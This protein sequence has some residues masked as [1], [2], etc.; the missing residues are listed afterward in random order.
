MKYM[1]CSFQGKKERHPAAC[2]ILDDGES[3]SGFSWRRMRMNKR[4][5][6]RL[7]SLWIG[8]TALAALTL[9][10][11]G[12]GG[13]GGL[14]IS[15]NVSRAEKTLPEMAVPGAQVKAY[16]WPDLA[17][18]IRSATTNADGNY[19]MSLPDSA[20]GKD[21][22][23]VADSDTR[24]AAVI[25]LSTIITDM[26]SGGKTV[27]DL[28]ASTTLAAETVV[29]K[30]K[31][32]S[33]PDLTGPAIETITKECRLWEGVRQMNLTPDGPELPAAFGGGLK[34]PSDADSFI[35]NSVIIQKAL[36]L[37]AD[38]SPSDVR[39]A[40]RMVQ[41]LRDMAH[42]LMDTA[43]VNNHSLDTAAR[44]QQ[45]IEDGLRVVSHDLVVRLVAVANLVGLGGEQDEKLLGGKN[46]DY[47][48]LGGKAPGKYEWR[49]NGDSR[50]LVKVAEVLDGKTWMVVSKIP[51]ATE[52]W[53]ITITPQNRV[54]EFH[55]TPKAGSY[56]VAVRKPG[57][58]TWKWDMVMA[59]VLDSA[60]RT[61]KVTISLTANDPD[62]TR[63]IVFN[64]TV[65]G[66]PTGTYDRPDYSQITVSGNLSSQFVSGE[67]GEL[68]IQW[69]KDT[70]YVADM[71]R[72]TINNFRFTTGFSKTISG[73]IRSATI[74]Y[75]PANP[76]TTYYFAPPRRAAITQATLEFSGHKIVFSNGEI[77]LDRYD[78][79]GNITMKTRSMKGALNYTSP[80]MTFDGSLSA[81]W[82]NL[83]LH[84]FTSGNHVPIRK[85]PLGTIN[86]EGFVLP[87]SG[88]RSFAKGS[89]VFAVNNLKATI[90][91]NLDTL[92]YGSESMS[93]FV[94]FNYNIF[95]DPSTFSQNVT[96]DHPVIVVRMG[97]SPSGYKMNMDGIQNVMTGFIA[98]DE[99][100]TQKLADIGKA[101]DLQLGELGGTN[102][103][104]YRDNTF[105]TLISILPD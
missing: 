104:K 45:A 73:S 80:K 10:G 19:T 9:P 60:N 102:I 51:D 34:T 4:I 98:R 54:D 78:K 105:E 67:L 50:A 83:T 36:A 68:T 61:T 58:P 24:V 28:D 31:A 5:A 95:G 103:V 55:V 3:R 81:N 46:H 65:T 2:R 21:V 48:T 25:R 15:G 84:D 86:F 33:L 92:E 7:C 66:L 18:P 91:L 75:Y 82:D 76:Q 26:P 89:V 41:M 30:A 70:H 29:E 62:L 1:E 101:S 99:A 27:A 74:E 87:V 56:T 77:T 14:Q 16:V 40:K 94:Q 63:P 59:A 23:L 22:V 12:G 6:I 90:R 32:G 69:T 97:Q 93:G 52:N 96:L 38:T 79:D 17:T 71:K 39:S 53:E 44:E 49:V 37:L 43:T 42:G 57:Q 11:C 100:G 47:E 64:G 20:V 88:T 85:W 8:L 72:A 35:K 13:G